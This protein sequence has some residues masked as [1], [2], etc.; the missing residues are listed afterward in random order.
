MYDEVENEAASE[1][2][3]LDDDQQMDDSAHSEPPNNRR[4]ADASPNRDKH[5]QLVNCPHALKPSKVL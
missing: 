4:R 1:E 3:L 2:L 5:Q